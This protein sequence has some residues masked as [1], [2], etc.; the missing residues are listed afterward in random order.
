ML[1]F[2]NNSNSLQVPVL[3]FDCVFLTHTYILYHEL[4]PLYQSARLS[5]SCHLE[6]Y[7][8]KFL[9]LDLFKFFC[10][11]LFHCLI[12][13][14]GCLLSLAAHSAPAFHPI[15]QRLSAPDICTALSP[16][17]PSCGGWPP[18]TCFLSTSSLPGR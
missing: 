12:L 2:S 18:S 5:I 7:I 3:S 15:Y 1:V 9:F 13:G 6:L 11:S 17:F 8:H 14:I 4:H 10:V 16:L